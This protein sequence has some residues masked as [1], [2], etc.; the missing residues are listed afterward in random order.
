L[1]KFLCDVFVCFIGQELPDWLVRLTKAI[2]TMNKNVRM[3][4][5]LP[6]PPFE[7]NYVVH[8]SALQCPPPHE[9]GDAWPWSPLQELH[10]PS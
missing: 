6:D 9:D 4:R 3:R 1:C 8:D 5:C 2:L 7:L 10:F